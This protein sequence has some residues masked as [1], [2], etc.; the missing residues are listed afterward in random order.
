MVL[1]SNRKQVNVWLLRVIKNTLGTYIIFVFYYTFNK[2][3]TI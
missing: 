3:A 2:H 1:G